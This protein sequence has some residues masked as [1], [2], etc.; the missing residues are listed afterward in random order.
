MSSAPLFT[1]AL[2]TLRDANDF[3]GRRFA[4]LLLSVFGRLA[5]FRICAFG[6]SS[7]VDVSEGMVRAQR[8][9]TSV[10]ANANVRHP[11]CSI[12]LLVG[13]VVSDG[14]LDVQ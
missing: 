11:A 14:K 6:V 4:P 2:G 8:V 10:K 3:S 13:M 5:H 9:T 1:P 7:Y 12:P